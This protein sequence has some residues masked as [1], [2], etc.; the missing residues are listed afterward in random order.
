MFK[1]SQKNLPQ[2]PGVYLF[3]DRKDHVLYVGKA[4]NLKKRVAS[5]F[6]PQKNLTPDKYLMMHHATNLEHMIVDN[7]TEALLLEH[8]LIQKY[9]PPYNVVLKDDKSYVY[10]QIIDEKFPRIFLTRANQRKN[11]QKG[12][13]FGPY[14]SSE[15]ARETLKTL[16]QIFP[17]RSC[18]TLARHTCLFYHLKL[19]PGPCEQKISPTEYQEVIHEIIRFLRGQHREITQRITKE[20]QAASKHQNFER[21]AILR[22]RLLALQK[23]QEKQKVITR[24][25]KSQDVISFARRKK[26]AAINLFIIRNGRLLGKENFILLHTQGK[27][28]NE[29]LQSFVEEYYLKKEPLPQEII[30]PADISKPHFLKSDILIPQ[31]GLKKKLIEMG[32]KN[33]E[34]HLARHLT[35]IKESK[36]KN[37]KILGELASYLKLKKIPARIEAY[38]ISN[39]QGQEAT[40]SMIVFKNGVKETSSYRR[41]KIKTLKTPNDVAMLREVFSRRFARAKNK[42][43]WPLPDLILVDGGKGQLNATLSILQEKNI[44]IPIRALAKKLEQIYIPHQKGPLNIP[45]A[46]AS[47][48]LLKRIRDEA[49]RFAVS[50]HHK[51]R[52]KKLLNKKAN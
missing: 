47:L 38:D 52:S 1:L 16:R 42:T 17:F 20:M 51:L 34:E 37:Q 35:S 31:K 24:D 41:F 7:E 25:Q 19:C 14:T 18:K 8:T 29:I 21:A 48:M 43:S 40:G 44:P 12:K 36:V 46:S 6:Q 2:K 27:K 5:Y 39:I 28:D 50:Y 49:H 4:K 33:A 26:I 13:L 9:R 23:I 45:P 3:R 10:I 11:Y 15:D 22:D 32:E 30:L